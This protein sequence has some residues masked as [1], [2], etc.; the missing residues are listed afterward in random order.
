MNIPHNLNIVLNELNT[1]DILKEI[2]DLELLDGAYHDQYDYIVK[3]YQID[4]DWNKIAQVSEWQ[5]IE[6]LRNLAGEISSKISGYK[7]SSDILDQANDEDFFSFSPEYKKSIT[8]IVEDEDSNPYERY[9]FYEEVKD[10]L[11][12]KV[13]NQFNKY[14][15]KETLSF[16]K[17]RAHIKKIGFWHFQDSDFLEYIILNSVTFK[18]FTLKEITEY[19]G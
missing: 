2:I 19:T 15:I 8:G 11:K 16:K 4:N 3:K 12:L 14:S 17:L 6:I 18:N 9:D 10:N 13:K 1:D 7:H 5:I